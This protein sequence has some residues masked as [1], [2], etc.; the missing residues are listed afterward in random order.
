MIS[1]LDTS[2]Y[3]QYPIYIIYSNWSLDK[4]SDFLTSMVNDGVGLLKII[5]DNVGNETNKTLALISD[6]LYIELL[7]KGYGINKY[8]ADF[9]IKKYK[10]DKTKGL[11]PSPDKSN[12]L[13]IPV[14][15]SQKSNE[16]FITN[17]L[18]TKL[19]IFVK[20][21]IIPA[22]CW[23]I[24]CPLNSRELGQIKLGCF[25]FF[26]PEIPDTTIGVVKFL[27]QNLH[28]VDNTTSGLDNSKYDNLIKCY[29]ANHK[30]T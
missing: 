8:C 19:E 9:I 4:L 17:V 25:I 23:R 30:N 6:A 5:Y 29:W 21:N 12:N 2:T 7:V 22:E 28:W 11:S 3:N 1:Y 18:N 26:K 15:S 16:L 20:Y 24:K 14:P 13:F 10:F 27:M